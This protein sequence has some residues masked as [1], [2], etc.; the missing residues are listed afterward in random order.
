MGACTEKNTDGKITEQLKQVVRENPGEKIT[1][2]KDSIV[3]KYGIF[4]KTEYF[5][6]KPIKTIW[7][8][9]V[10]KQIQVLSISD[11]WKLTHIDSNVPYILITILLIFNL[12]LI[13]LFVKMIL[14]IRRNIKKSKETK[15]EIIRR[16]KK[17]YIDIILTPLGLFVF[18]YIAFPEDVSNITLIEIELTRVLLILLIIVGIFLRVYFISKE[19]KTE[20][21]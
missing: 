14:S 19:S 12:C 10:S 9:E 5:Y 4:E 20:K 17:E 3:R 8:D 13:I 11:K 1:I 15:D 18:L 6:K 2:Y 7:Y 16:L 21:N